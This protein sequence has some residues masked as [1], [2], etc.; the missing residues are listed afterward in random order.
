[1]I[2]ERR[3]AAMTLAATGLGLFLIFLDATII[4][5]AIPDIQRS[6]DTG[7]SGMQWVVAAYSLTM[8]MF[9]MTGATF[10]DLRGRRRTYVIG[11]VVFCGASL[12]CS[13]APTLWFLVVARGVQGVGAA[14]LNVASLALV[15]AAFPDPRAK[16]KAIGIWTGVATIAL[17]IGP[18]VGGVLTEQVG[19]RSVF[20][21]NPVFGVLAIVLTYRYVGES[22]DPRPRSFDVPGQLLFIVGIGALTFALIQAPQSGWLSAPI[23][24]A[25]AAAVATLVVFVRTELR[26]ADP[27]MEVRVFLEKVYTTALVTIFSVIFCVYGALFIITQYLQNVR[28]FSAQEAGLMMLALSIPAMVLSPITGRIVAAHGGRGPALAGLACA[29]AGTGVWVVGEA[30][31]IPITLV[32]LAFMGAAAGLGNPAATGVAMDD[33]PAERSGMA[34]GILSS[35]R[36]L[37]STAG[38]AVMGSILAVTISVALPAKLEPLVPDASARDQI[39][40]QVA[41]DAN[42]AA[43]ASMIGPGQPLPDNVAEDD[44]VLAATDAVFV[45]GIRLAML[46]GMLVATAAFVLGWFV[47]PR[48]AGPPPAP[49]EAVA[50]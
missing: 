46:A 32:G 29:I 34:S 17:A 42:P 8:A 23:V 36:A 12:G 45:D 4:N 9:M 25:F 33:I 40:T 39:A 37:G 21:F 50:A 7:E 24:A 3:R 15:G 14:V 47:F 41:T 30:A 13:L 27:M 44:A 5:V 11:L 10:G 16:A 28:G 26:S 48:R 19:W 31:K 6:F 38:F 2:T 1:V 20:V 18:T 22:K 49:S 35:Q 43:E